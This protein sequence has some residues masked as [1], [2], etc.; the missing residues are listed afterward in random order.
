MEYIFKNGTSIAKIDLQKIW[1]CEYSLETKNDVSW[2]VEKYIKF[3][4]TMKQDENHFIILGEIFR[5]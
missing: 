5:V 3:E 1:V 2:H 4:Y